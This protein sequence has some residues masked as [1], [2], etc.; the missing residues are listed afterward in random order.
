M[1]SVSW[2]ALDTKK[3]EVKRDVDAALAEYG[4]NE[5]GAWR[6][7]GVGEKE[8]KGCSACRLMTCVLV[9][10]L[11]DFICLVGCFPPPP[12]W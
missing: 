8:E 5:G 10:P 3:R 2:K 4:I 6:H 11:V 7:V 1:T 12:F 9:L